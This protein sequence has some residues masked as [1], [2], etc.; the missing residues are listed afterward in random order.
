MEIDVKTARE[1]YEAKLNAMVDKF[2]CWQLP[3]DFGPDCYISFDRE[4]A[5]KNNGRPLADGP[6]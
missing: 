1:R 3:K 2:L 5:E 6:A 4:K